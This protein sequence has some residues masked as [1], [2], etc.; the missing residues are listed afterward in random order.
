M[1]KLLNNFAK[2]EEICPSLL[3][4]IKNVKERFIDKYEAALLILSRLSLLC[5]LNRLWAYFL[6]G[7]S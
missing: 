7:M 1:Q 2:D 5:D 4:C 6:R 3:A